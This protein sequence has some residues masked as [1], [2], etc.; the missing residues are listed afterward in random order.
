M[1]KKQQARALPLAGI[2]WTGLTK[3]NTLRR[4]RLG[5]CVCAVLC[6]CEF[7]RSILG[8]QSSSRP[9]GQRGAEPCN[10]ANVWNEIPSL[11]ARGCTVQVALCNR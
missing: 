10:R 7:F 3:A 8:H 9:Q 2:T 4:D 1:M 6:L 5:L 11:C